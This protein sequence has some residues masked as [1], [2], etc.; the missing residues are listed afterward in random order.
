MSFFKYRISSVH[1]D[2]NRQIQLL[3]VLSR[4]RMGIDYMRVFNSIN[5]LGA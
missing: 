5:M 3:Q 1:L 4:L 2:F